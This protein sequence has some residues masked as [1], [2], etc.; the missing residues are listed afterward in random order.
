MPGRPRACWSRPRL[1]RLLDLLVDAVLGAD[2]LEQRVLGL[3]AEADR[4]AAVPVDDAGDLVASHDKRGGT[5][6]AAGA[7]LHWYG[8][9][10]IR[11]VGW[12][13]RPERRRSSLK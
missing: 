9:S 6:D 1:R 7:R 4:R 13:A 12:C 5:G 11:V 10:L 8:S 3:G 2:E